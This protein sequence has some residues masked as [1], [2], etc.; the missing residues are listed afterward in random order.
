MAAPAEVKELARALGRM[1]YWVY[2]P[3]LKGHGTAPEDLATRKFADWIESVD[4]MS[5]L[6]PDDNPR[7]LTYYFDGDHGIPDGWIPIAHSGYGDYTVLSVRTEDYGRVFYLFHEV[8]GYDASNRSEGVYPLATSFTEWI[9][10][11]DDLG[12]EE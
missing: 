2:A 1:G 5:G 8:H 6:G 10:S 9:A 12:E 11:L 4:E 7:S 3:R